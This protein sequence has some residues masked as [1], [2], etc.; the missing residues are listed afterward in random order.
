VAI[1][2]D[3]RESRV[4]RVAAASAVVLAVGALVAVAAWRLAGRREAPAG[5][6]GGAPA[7]PAPGAV[8]SAVRGVTDREILLGMVASFSGSNKE[9][10]RSMRA[11]WETA[12]ATANEAGGIHGRTLRLVAL[13]DG[14]DPAR[15][16]PALKD[17]V[18][19]RRV[20]G[21]VGNVGTATAAVSVPYCMQNKVLFYGALSGADL[22]R[23]TPPDRY[24]FNYR[25]G[26]AREGAAAVRYLVKVR[27]VSPRRIAVLVQMD[28]F[29]E[30]GWRGAV[31]ELESSGVGREQILKLGYPRNTADVRDAVAQLKKR[32][33][34]HDAV[35]MVATYKPAATFVIQA[36]EAGLNLFFISVSADSN[37]LAEDL[38]AAGRRYTEKV[39]IT[40]VV[41]VPSSLLPGVTRYRQ[42]LE[43]HALAEKPGSTTLEA[44]VGAQILLE[45]LSRAGRD[46]DGEKVVEALESI[47]RWDVGIGAVIDLGPGD[48]QGSDTVWGWLLQPDG[49]YRQI[50]LG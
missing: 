36:K 38:V 23:K 47:R 21:L 37:G 32:P 3:R 4:L 24:V 27:R 14:Y 18:E 20:F 19:N 33:K 6:A 39:A 34:A 16:M 46:L 29:G 5:P 25:A 10:G 9:R 49:T 2:G 35:V 11:G 42:L 40:Q 1:A 41:P 45:A 26:L 50:D 22:L 48:H 15:T 7:A 30:S 12:L 28:D 13:D 44:W 17:L 43:K 31:R 8:A